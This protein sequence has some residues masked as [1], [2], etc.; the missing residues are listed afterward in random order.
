MFFE[1]AK[2]IKAKLAAQR[3]KQENPL[4]VIEPTALR[5]MFIDCAPWSIVGK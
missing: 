5:E 3:K 4:L 1:G 2:Q